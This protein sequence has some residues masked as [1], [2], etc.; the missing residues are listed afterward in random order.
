MYHL[1]AVLTPNVEKETEPEHVIVYQDTK[2]IRTRLKR[3]VDENVK[4]IQI[5]LVLLLA[6]GLNVLTHAQ[7]LVV[8]VQL[9]R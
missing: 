2:E 7:E 3:V 5:A 6:L 8:P 1:L 9:V 4:S